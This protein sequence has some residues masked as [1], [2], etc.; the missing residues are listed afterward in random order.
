MKTGNRL[1]TKRLTLWGAVA[2]AG[3]LVGGLLWGAIGEPLLTK[4]AE[5]RG[6][7]S[8]PDGKVSIAVSFCY[9]VWSTYGTHIV[10]ACCA[11]VLGLVMGIACGPHVQRSL[12]S[13]LNRHG[14]SK[15]V[16]LTRSEW[17]L[18][19]LMFSQGEPLL[20]LKHTEGKASLRLGNETPFAAKAVLSDAE[21]QAALNG[22][23]AKGLI[24]DRFGRK[25]VYEATTD[26]LAL[27]QKLRFSRRR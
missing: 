24:S 6:I 8:D 22:L 13:M 26:G 11:L 19:K 3:V 15:S 21:A 23:V 7:V 17:T 25:E 5:N 2:G 10:V 4:W 16:A 18:L 27:A 20:L 12:T 1:E 9:L 14:A